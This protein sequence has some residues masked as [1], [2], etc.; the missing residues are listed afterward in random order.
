MNKCKS[1]FIAFL[2]KSVFDILQFWE[3]MS[4]KMGCFNFYIYPLQFFDL[5]YIEVATNIVLIVT[6]SKGQS[7][8]YIS[9]L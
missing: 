6:H 5:F 8:T 7:K 4:I 3:M 9:G 2:Q 1:Y